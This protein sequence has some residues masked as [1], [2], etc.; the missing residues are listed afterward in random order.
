VTLPRAPRSREATP[1]EGDI[2]RDKDALAQARRGTWAGIGIVLFMYG[3]LR[4][5]LGPL[6]QDPAYHV[7][8][9]TRLCGPI[10]R[11]GDV[12]TNLAIL[13][14]GLAGVALRR[15]VRLA[16][17]ERPAYALLVAGM[18]L[19][20]LGSAYYH[21]APSDARLAWDRLPMTLVLAALV[22]LVLADRI[23][24]AFARAAWWPLAMLG[25]GS[26]LWWAWTRNLG[27]DD[28]LPYLLVYVGSG[29]AIVSLLLSRRGRHVGSGWL[30]VVIAIQIAMVTCERLDHEIFAATRMLVS[31]HNLKHLL[32]GAL[33][34]CVLAWLARREAAEP[35]GT[36]VA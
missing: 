17:E 11:A 14:A 5:Y 34:G 25:A 19:T 12:L 9:D 15:R 28:L 8:A 3:V 21:W 36:A 4:F 24:P 20:A 26:V 29:A 13:A 6:P 35:R 2:E 31:G 22:A 33:L 10:P 32:A 23:H 16:R 30:F 18:L 7:F 27:A 1:P